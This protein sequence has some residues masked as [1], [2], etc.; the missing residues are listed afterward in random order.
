MDNL[1]WP[2]I[3]I[4]QQ[5]V[6][7]SFEHQSSSMWSRL[8]WE[9]VGPSHEPFPEGIPLSDQSLPLQQ[10]HYTNLHSS[11]FLGVQWYQ[12]IHSNSS[13]WSLNSIG[14]F[15]KGSLGQSAPW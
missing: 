8:Q 7:H 5:V 9:N 15:V 4:M 12:D 1:F 13:N 3:E 6:D 11:R 2:I 14:G 10:Y